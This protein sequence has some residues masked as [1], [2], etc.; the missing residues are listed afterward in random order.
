MTEKKVRWGIMSTA[1]IGKRSVIPGIQESK[2]NVV[3]AV[4]S[5]SL[6]NAQ[7]FADELGIPKAYGSYEELLNDP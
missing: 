7:K 4:A 6:E 5:R 2:R 3:A 1:S